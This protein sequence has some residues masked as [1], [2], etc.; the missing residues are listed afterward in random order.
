MGC[1]FGAEVTNA[2]FAVAGAANEQLANLARPAQ[3]PSA[4]DPVAT[5]ERLHGAIQVKHG[6]IEVDFADWRDGQAVAYG[7]GNERAYRLAYFPRGQ[8]RPVRVKGPDADEFLDVAV[9]SLFAVRS[10]GQAP[11]LVV[12]TTASRAIPG[13][14]DARSQG[15]DVFTRLANGDIVRDEAAS[16]R[17]QDV[18]TAAEARRRLSR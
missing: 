15:G 13:M 1:G 18:N 7:V 14:S 6:P 10:M 11:R 16:A 8:A 12:L 5:L 2:P 3:R 4:T 17:L 9:T